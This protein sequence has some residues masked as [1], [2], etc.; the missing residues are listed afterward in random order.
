MG[1]VYDRSQEHLGTSDAMIIRSRRRLLNAAQTFADT[2][3]TPLT[4]QHPEFYRIRS[5]STLLPV[6]ANWMA[7]T[8]QLREAFVEHPELDWS[9]TGGA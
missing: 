9:V 7:A 1:L 5:G 3:K 4:V 2:G 8:E 6:D